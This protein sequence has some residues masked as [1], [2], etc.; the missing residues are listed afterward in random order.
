MLPQCN[1]FGDCLE[2][3]ALQ[4]FRYCTWNEL[5]GENDRPNAFLEKAWQVL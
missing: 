3:L 4:L 1:S 5:L 2:L